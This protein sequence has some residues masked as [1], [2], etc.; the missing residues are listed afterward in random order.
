MS[1]QH[2]V[3]YDA[4]TATA[5]RP[6]ATRD[7]WVGTGRAARDLGLKPTEF[8]LAVQLGR[9]RTTAGDGGGGAGGSPAPR[10]SGYGPGPGSRS[11]CTGA[12][13]PWAPRRAPPSSA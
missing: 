2:T 10:S 9:V 8:D 12:C 1:G 3:T 13:G 11:P 7:T 6:A 4:T 5:G